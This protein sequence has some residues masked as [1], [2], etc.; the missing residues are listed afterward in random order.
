MHHHP[1]GTQIRHDENTAVD[2]WLERSKAGNIFF[3]C[4]G[5]PVDEYLP[6]LAR[7]C[8]CAAL[9]TDGAL[10]PL[11]RLHAT[12]L[13]LLLPK[14]CPPGLPSLPLLRQL[15]RC[16]CLAHPLHGQAA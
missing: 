4:T 11:Y 15:A 6:A 13:K 1:L 9:H 16:C 14:G 2:T 7:A 3:L 5:A 10:E 12:R 8:R